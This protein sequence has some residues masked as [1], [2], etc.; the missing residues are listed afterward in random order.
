MRLL[1][2]E[3]QVK[4]RS[5]TNGLPATSLNKLKC[6]KHKFVCNISSTS[7]FNLL[8]FGQQSH[9]LNCIFAGCFWY[10]IFCE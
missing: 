1:S 2:K 7:S 3:K 8:F 10:T 9:K 5:W 4:T 6:Y